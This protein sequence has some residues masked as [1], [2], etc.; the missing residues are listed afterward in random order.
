M[1]ETSANEEYRGIGM[2]HRKRLSA[3]KET[4]P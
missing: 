2:I 1:R 4:A 3:L